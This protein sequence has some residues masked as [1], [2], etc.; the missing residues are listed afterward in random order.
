MNLCINERLIN[1]IWIYIR[2]AISCFDEVDR[3]RV[4]VANF[5]DLSIN[6]LEI[7]TRFVKTSFILRPIAVLILSVYLYLQKNINAINLNDKINE[8]SV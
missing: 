8:L 7:G 4:V 3:Q 2:I 6:A 1:S 5:G